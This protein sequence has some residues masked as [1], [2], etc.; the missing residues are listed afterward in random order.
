[1]KN[2]LLTM[3][4]SL[5]LAACGG[6]GDGAGDTSP[7]PAV[8]ALAAASSETLAG[9]KAIDLSASGVS[10]NVNWQLAAGSPGSLSAS[11]GATVRY[12]PPATLKDNARVT[13]TAT[14]GASTQ[15]ITL[16]VY[17]DPGTPGLY[18]MAGDPNGRPYPFS[19]ADKDGAAADARF[20]GPST[21][22][23][24][25]QGNVYVIENQNPSPSKQSGLVLRKLAAAGQV[26]TLADYSNWFGKPGAQP[27]PI[28]I[29]PSGI[30]TD[31]QGNLFISDRQVLSNSRSLIHK[32]GADGANTVF[33]GTDQTVSASVK[34]G[35]GKD[36]RFSAPTLLGIDGA[37]NLY[38]RDDLDKQ[39]LRKITP[40]AVVTTIDSLPA[41]LNADLNGNIYRI[42]PIRFVVLQRAKDGTERVIAGVD[43]VG[44]NRLGALP[45]G[46]ARPVA[47]AR[48]GPASYAVIAE[49]AILKLV[50]PH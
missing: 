20:F 16:T 38:V 34:D 5:F 25:R 36:A 3:S 40:Q 15:S 45:G 2:T 42:D 50:V 32:L 39:F 10:V 29:Y 1:M 48:L 13:V 18:L 21:L 28:F 24:D 47:I 23:A 11:S 19:E 26:S 37:D 33:A 4:L 44:G 49:T 31:S 35:T 14:A 7:P 6:G 43:G 17:P 12:Q 22:A 41:D 9:G 27:E 46:L 8:L 30:A